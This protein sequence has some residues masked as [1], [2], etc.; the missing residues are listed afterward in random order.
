[1]FKKCRYCGFKNPVDVDRCLACK[2][3][4]PETLAETRENLQDMV[5]AAS[6]KADKVIR[7]RGRQLVTDQVSAVK[8]RFHP[9]WF[10]KVKLHRLK[11]ALVNIFWIFAIIG[12]VVVFGLLF[13]FF[14]KFFNK[15]G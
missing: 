14:S 8:Y 5:D 3:E 15:G 6:G 7:K 4:L 9:G 1:M 12:G 2:K 11:R 10:L 13:N